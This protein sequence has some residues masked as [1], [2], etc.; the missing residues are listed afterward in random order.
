[1]IPNSNNFVK[2]YYLVSLAD[3]IYVDLQGS[4]IFALPVPITMKILSIWQNPLNKLLGKSE[5]EE[6]NYLMGEYVLVSFILQ[7]ISG[8]SR[9]KCLIFLK[10]I[11]FFQKNYGIIL[12]NAETEQTVRT[13][14]QPGIELTKEI[15]A[16]NGLNALPFTF[17]GTFFERCGILGETEKQVS[18]RSATGS[19]YTPATIA[20]FIVDKT[21]EVGNFPEPL[22]KVK[23]LDPAC[24]GGIFLVALAEA[25]LK[26]KLNR[27]PSH[28]DA[29]IDYIRDILSRQIWGIDLSPN[30]QRV[31]QLQLILWAYSLVPRIDLGEISSWVTHCSQGDFLFTSP[32]SLPDISI[33]VANPP[34]GN[35][36][37]YFQKTEVEKWATTRSQEISELF[38]ERALG[39]LSPDGC[40]GFVM[41]K[42]MAYYIA[43]SRAR[44]L[45]LPDRLE[46]VADLGLSFPGVNFETL[47]LF[48]KKTPLTA[49][50]SPLPIFAVD[51]GTIG[52][53][54]RQYIR[55]TN[56]IPLQPLDPEDEN[57]IEI[58]RKNCVT[59][60]YQI[61][62]YYNTRGIYLPEKKKTECKAGNVLW[63]NRVPDIQHYAIRRLWK[64]DHEVVSHARFNRFKYLQVPKILV[65]VLR[66]RKLSAIPDPWGILMPTEKL[67]SI[68]LENA[69]PREI[70]AWN[71]CIN[72][73]PASF[74][75]QKVVFSQTTESARVLDDPYFEQ[76]PILTNLTQS[77][78]TLSGINLALSLA[79]QINFLFP[80]VI[81]LDTFRDT[82]MLFQRIMFLSY[83]GKTPNDNKLS[84]KEVFDNHLQLLHNL[85]VAMAIDPPAGGLSRNNLFKLTRNPE[86]CLEFSDELTSR[87]QAYAEELED[88]LTSGIVNK[89]TNLA[90]MNPVWQ[91]FVDYFDSKP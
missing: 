39:I 91:K 75:L 3:V 79:A 5:N 41:P 45:V 81:P 49:A 82:G 8:I 23:C 51:K 83:M 18:A 90:E 44:K 15:L 21:I 67:V 85:F 33:I 40:L 68:L 34:F 72:G 42:T 63:L 30:A 26:S 66:G 80:K 52:T 37:D 87:V 7:Q 48:V 56:L 14:F 24:G 61:R 71:A 77:I 1:M 12:E 38:L 58:I 4:G 59:H 29:K 6:I 76:I 36:L 19:F 32:E 13:H 2:Q 60:P 70:L 74:Y 65:K 73:W 22:E 17:L 27:S 89:M 20:Q 57:L 9:E 10:N 43:W 35:L 47:I 84:M 64:I 16:Q 55:N 25:L 50:G 53:F 28:S 88:L 86:K 69:S 62:S 46:G 11:P 54:P 31:S 78:N